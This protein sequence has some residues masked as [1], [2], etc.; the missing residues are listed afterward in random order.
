MATDD[1]FNFVFEC[2]LSGIKDSLGNK[3]PGIKLSDA[4][5]KHKAELCGYYNNIKTSIKN[6]YMYD[7]M[8]PLDR[9]KCAGAFMVAFLEKLTIKENQLNK[10]FLAIFIG[11]LILKIFIYKECKDNRDLSFI[12]F[13]N[14]QGGFVF[15][16]CDCDLEPY[17]YN[18]ALGMHYDRASEQGK[19]IRI[20]S[21]LALSNVLFL[22]EKYNRNLAGLKD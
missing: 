20:L 11:L 18:W 5:L 22:I 4:L 10:E 2:A 1:T 17:K 14:R 19:D 12:T 9:H 7:P 15:P 3:S 8:R 16:K 6:T 21:P 13:I